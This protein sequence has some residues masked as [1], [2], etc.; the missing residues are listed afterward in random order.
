VNASAELRT[1]K[2]YFIDNNSDF[3]FFV[4][5]DLSIHAH[6]NTDYKNKDEYARANNWLNTRKAG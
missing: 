3:G 1:L 5:K 6:K 2:F 4:I